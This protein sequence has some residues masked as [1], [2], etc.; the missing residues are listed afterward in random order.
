MMDCDLKKVFSKFDLHSTA[1]PYGD[2]HINDTYVTYSKAKRYIL[3]RI[4]HNVFK[5]P[6]E[7]MSNITAVTE[8]LRKKI[9][10]NG[11]N[12]D[13]ETL[14]VIK[15]LDGSSYY[16]SDSGNY[17]RMYLFIEGAKTYQ[18][19]EQPIHFYSA[20]KAF[21]RFQKL[22]ADFPSETLYETI[23]DFHNTKVRFS[24][25]LNAI[26][27]DKMG[28]VKEV[29][30]EIEFA[31]KREKYASVV[32]DLLQSG[33]LPLRVTHND[34]KYNNIMFDDI[35]GEAVCVIDLD[36]VNPGSLLYDFGDSIR[37]GANPAP[38]DE[39]D[40]SKV[41][42][43]LELFE[44]FTKGFTEELGNE[45]T[46]T[47]KDHLAFSAKLMTFECGMR[48]LADYLNGDT[49]FKTHYPKQNL[50]RTKTQFKLVFDMEEKKQKMESIV[51][52]YK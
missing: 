24:Q 40:L 5:K 10:Q 47:E 11:G 19:A 29:E 17:Y 49:Y 51:G 44:C 7:V 45:L 22:L 21:A 3:Q 34:T 32:V 16:K 20:A 30:A 13:R 1:E 39:K 6:D 37:F 38:E 42:C 4:N 14:T 48:F 2:G 12:P 35:T 52:K 9:I 41:F 33:K 8:H 36:T 26:K 23:P 28:R 15:T 27:D 31:L 43:D 18:V 46:E 25:L 50:Y